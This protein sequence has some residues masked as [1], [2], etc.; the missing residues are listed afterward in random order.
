MQLSGYVRKIRSASLKAT[1]ARQT[2]IVFIAQVTGTGLSYLVQVLLARTLSLTDYGA[3]AYT[4]SWVLLIGM[5]A[6]L[7]FH[8]AVLRFVS[9]YRVKQEWGR[10]RGVLQRSWHLT[11]GAGVLLAIVG[12]VVVLWIDSTREF[13]YAA[14]L[15]VGVWMFPLQAL[16]TLNQA[17]FRAIQRITTGYVLPLVV[18]PLLIMG[19]IGLFLLI[20]WPLTDLTAI[21]LTAFVIGSIVLAMRWTFWRGMATE[22]ISTPPIYETGTW[23]RVSLPMLLAS[24]S[25]IIMKQTDVLMVGSFLGAKEAAL[26]FAATRIST[27]VAFVLQSVNAV[28]APSF[29]ALHAAGDH[30]GLQRLVTTVSHWIFWPSC[31]II[32]ALVLFAEPVL[33][34]FGPEFTAARWVLIILMGAQVVNAWAGS[35]GFLLNMTGHQDSSAVVFVITAILNVVL[36]AIAIPLFGVIGAACSTALTMAMWNIWLYVLVIRKLGI[37]PSFIGRMISEQWSKE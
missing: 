5:L 32:A 16:L 31:G 27:L 14:P 35:V 25:A 1:L 19:G 15:L 26:Y 2:G 9:E 4:L 21:G 23:L 33:W 20:G 17:T 7:G 13:V 37:Y 24:G 36:N 34:L 18:R 8:T 12:T 28:S 29:A 11:Y 30:A 22:I 10:V 3:Y 6:P